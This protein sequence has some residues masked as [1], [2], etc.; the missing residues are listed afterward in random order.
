MAAAA[1]GDG[2]DSVLSDDGAG[3]NCAFPLTTATNVCSNN[4]FANNTGIVRFGDAVTTHPTVGCGPEAPA[5]S[6]SSGTVFVN[7]QGAGRLGDVYSANTITS[8]SSNVFIG[9]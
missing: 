6:S 4:V 1:R 9:N 2:V 7:G 8:G 3:L 5:L